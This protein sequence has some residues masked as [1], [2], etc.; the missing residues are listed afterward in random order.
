MDGGDPP[1]P[2]QQ[3]HHQKSFVPPPP[4]LQHLD[5]HV[6]GRLFRDLVDN[7]VDPDAERAVGDAEINR[8]TRL[9]DYKRIAAEVRAA[10]TI[11]REHLDFHELEAIAIANV[12][13]GNGLN[14]YLGDVVVWWEV[15]RDLRDEKPENVARAW[16]RYHR[17][18]VGRVS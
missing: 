11:F 14:A 2:R 3:H 1:R 17:H 5:P 7:P 6:P 12:G 16:G 13:D 9:A 15:F 18:R 4:D 8:L 10:M